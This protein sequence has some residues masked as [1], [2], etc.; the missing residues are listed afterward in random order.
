MKEDQL[1]IRQS[2]KWGK[3]FVLGTGGMILWYF[4]G[5]YEKTRVLYSGSP[6]FTIFLGITIFALF[7][8]FSI[9]LINRKA[10]ITLTKNGI[11]LRGKGYFDW[12]FL[13][14]FEIVHHYDD[15]NTKNLILHLNGFSDVNFDITY[16]EKN[17][18]ELADLIMKYK[19]SAN[20]VFLNQ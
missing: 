17:R 13:E 18:N 14:S 12:Q 3:F 4:F 10:E 8:Y 5:P 2:K 11:E 1:I 9:E 16:L 7:I 6:L 15:A 19:G 20:V